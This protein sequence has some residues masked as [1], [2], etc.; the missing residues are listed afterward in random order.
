MLSR[1]QIEEF[2]SLCD[3]DL[4]YLQAQGRI[5]RAIRQRSTAASA[6]SLQLVPARGSDTEQRTWLT[7]TSH[8]LA[9]LR[10]AK[11]ETR[12]RHSRRA[13]RRG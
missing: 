9:K 8:P 3:E 12:L 2:G 13:F 5:L 4:A 1:R 10:P 6:S 7:P 11:V